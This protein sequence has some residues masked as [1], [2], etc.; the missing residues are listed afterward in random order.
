MA[1]V[2]ISRNFKFTDALPPP[3]RAVMQDI[4]IDL[5]DKIEDRTYQGTDENGNTFPP[6]RKGKLIFPGPVT[7]HDTGFMFFSFQV[8]SVTE[9][10]VE[11]GFTNRKAE[12]IARYHTEGTH[13]MPPRPFLGVAEHWVED[14]MKKFRESYK[15]HQ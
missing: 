4:G 2:K 1:R 15:Q 14:V 5:R 12:Q 8:T 13:H 6:H 7:L 10:T 9:R 3:G 11:I